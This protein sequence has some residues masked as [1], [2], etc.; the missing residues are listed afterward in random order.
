MAKVAKKS[1]KVLGTKSSSAV[2]KHPPKKAGQ[3][4]DNPRKRGASPFGRK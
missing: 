1:V 2:G 3:V 4:K